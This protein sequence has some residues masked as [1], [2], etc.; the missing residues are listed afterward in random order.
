MTDQQQPQQ[1]GQISPDEFYAAIGARFGLLIGRLTVENLEL[2]KLAGLLQAKI[3]KLEAE[4][5][6]GKQERDRLVANAISNEDHIHALQEEVAKFVDQEEVIKELETTIQELETTIEGL[7]E[8]GPSVAQVAELEMAKTAT[9]NEKA[10][11]V[12]AA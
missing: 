3:A 6:E 10:A 9:R 1:P 2:Q 12:E 7:I 8:K 4:A 11:P 5:A